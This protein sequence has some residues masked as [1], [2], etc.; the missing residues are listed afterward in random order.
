MKIQVSYTYFLGRYLLYN[1][2]LKEASEELNKALKM[3]LILGQSTNVTHVLRFLIPVEM[4]AGKYATDEYLDKHG[5]AQEYKLIGHAVR[6]G[7]V[8]M[9]E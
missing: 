3:S 8:G 5:L 7:D 1:N 6:N 9:L 2:K 4:L